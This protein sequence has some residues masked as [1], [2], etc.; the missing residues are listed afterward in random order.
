[1][2][3][4]QIF[5]RHLFG[6][7]WA[8][9]FGPH[10]DVAPDQSG[11]LV[12][13][14][15]TDAENVLYE[16]DGGPR[17]MPGTAKL[18]S[19]QMESGAVV[20]GV[21]DYWI[22]GTGSNSAQHRIVNVGG[23]IKKDD[24]DG[25]FVDLF[26]GLDAAAVPNY[27]ILEDILIMA[28]DSSSDT[29]KSWDGSTAQDLAGSP[30]SFAFS[31]THKNRSWAA[32]VNP[33]SSRLYYSASLDG[34][35]W[36]GAGSGTIDI[37]P[38][39]GDRIT[40]IAS[41]R[42][43][44][45]VF[46]GPYKGSIHRIT[47]S[48]PTGDDGFARTTFVKGVGAVGQSTI[49]RFA[50]DLGFVWSDG[51]VRSLAATEKFGDFSETALS[52]PIQGG[53]INDRINISR[54]KFA[55]A[56]TDDI[57]GIVVFTVPIDSSQNNNVVLSMDYRFS[58]V[59]W[60]YLPAIAA[61]SLASV[62][63]QT[64]NNRRKIYFGGND[65]YVRKWGVSERTNDGTAIAYKVTTPFLSYGNS[66]YEKGISAIGMAMK[67]HNSGTV[68]FKW[69]RDAQSQQ[70]DTVTQGAGGTL[71]FTLGTD[72]LGGGTFLDRFLS[73][74]EGGIFRA[75]QYE[76]TQAVDSEDFELHAI[77]ALI[78]PVGLSLEN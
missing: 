73:L 64:N 3:T 10:S 30:P 37:D 51:T 43:D 14:F 22:T 27:S 53:F 62:V 1:M 17:K 18:N 50:N 75:I 32:G 9:D 13:P 76:I 19:S 21:F 38:R 56:A 2:T 28:N 41:H 44:L 15:L 34:E 58:P 40:A 66:A 29:P 39:D 49:F 11:T 59:R 20:R 61:G 8:T 78:R 60:S 74:E 31:E 70:T 4:K 24:A 45:W 71:P 57:R 47:G 54:L 67:P 26:T 72:V 42:N 63:D 69:Q 7:G 36:V 5:V 16:L 25:T 23:T 68:T 46:K 52:R 12:L 35:D 77:S 48:A 55:H 65:G 33:N 6:G